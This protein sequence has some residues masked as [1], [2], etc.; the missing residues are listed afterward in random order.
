MIRIGEYQTLTID[1]ELP[2]GFYLVDNDGDD[3]LYPRSYISPEMQ[4]GDKL[5]VFVYCDSYGRE[6]ATNETP[7]LTVGE[8]APLKVTHITRVGAFCEWG[9]SKELLIPHANQGHSLKEGLTYVVYMYLDNFSERLVG[10]TKLRKYLEMEADENLKMGQE[11][12]LIVYDFTDI[13]YKAVVDQKYNGLIYKNEVKQSL[14]IGQRLN[15]YVKPIREDGKID[16]SLE[17]VG[18]NSIGNNEDII[19]ERLELAH[20]FLPFHDKSDPQAIRKEFGMSKKLF[21]KIIGS[22]YKQRKIRIMKGGIWLNE[23]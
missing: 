9:T 4:V 19:L 2:Q 13:G 20:G 11:V 18:H 12:S 17:P 23:E 14:K 21:K 16:I 3:V 15:G 5:E 1:R 7:L 6:V 22:L 8:F 10:S